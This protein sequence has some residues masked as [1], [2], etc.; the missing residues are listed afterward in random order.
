[1]EPNP[2]DRFYSSVMCGRLRSQAKDKKH[3]FAYPR[4]HGIVFDPKVGRI[5]KLDLPFKQKISDYKHI[6]D[7]YEEPK[8]FR[9]E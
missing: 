9:D 3:P 2:F 4:V 7:L 1:V 5:N 6:Y 8:H